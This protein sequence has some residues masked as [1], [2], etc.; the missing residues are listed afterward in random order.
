MAEQVWGPALGWPGSSVSQARGHPPDRLALLP[1]A[2]EGSLRQQGELAWG[3]RARGERGELVGATLEHRV[4]CGA[5]APAL[6]R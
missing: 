1:L 5:R 6:P 4:H 3:I 2:R